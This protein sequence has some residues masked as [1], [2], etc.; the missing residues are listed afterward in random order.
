MH[1]QDTLRVKCQMDMQH[2]GAEVLCAM[3]VRNV[4]QPLAWPSILGD[5][6]TLRHF[7]KGREPPIP[8]M[9]VLRHNPLLLRDM[10]RLTLPA[11]R[12][13]V[14]EATTLQLGVDLRWLLLMSALSDGQ[15]AQSARF[16]VVSHLVQRFFEHC[17]PREMMAGRRLVTGLPS[18]LCGAGF[19]CPEILGA[20]RSTLR[21]PTRT[22]GVDGYTR[23]GMIEDMGVAEPRYELANMLGCSERD[24][25]TECVHYDLP[26]GL[27]VPALVGE[28]R[29]GAVMW[30][31]GRLLVWG[32]DADEPTDVTYRAVDEAEGRPSFFGGRSLTPIR[33]TCAFFR[34][35]VVVRFELGT[36]GSH[37]RKRRR[38]T[39]DARV[40]VVDGFEPRVG[41]YRVLY[42][43][44]GESDLAPHRITRMTPYE[45][46]EYVLPADSLLLCRIEG[47]RGRV[48]VELQD[49]ARRSAFVDGDGTLTEIAG[50]AS[51]E[52]MGRLEYASVDDLPDDG[53]L[54]EGC[55]VLRMKRVTAPGA[56][57]HDDLLKSSSHGRRI[58]L[59]YQERLAPLVCVDVRAIA[60]DAQDADADTV[61]THCRLMATD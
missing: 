32:D 54:P 49:A 10:V 30:R 47:I 51:M 27:W 36:D 6:G 48:R 15:L 39:S 55:V 44:E 2:D 56:Q 16:S 4:N 35:G 7:W 59:S 20:R 17:V 29:P 23:T 26:H 31:D 33:P 41:R 40:G 53:P 60:R 57:P 12:L 19:M 9:A 21:R 22:T 34:R 50:G 14:V 43:R 5:S 3:L 52:L 18:Q 45:V 24:L 38:S 42:R 61:H 25:P 8:A 46:E 37:Q 13:V 1:T 28:Q 11:L 58:R